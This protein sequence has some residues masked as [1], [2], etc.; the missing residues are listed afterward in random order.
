M[1]FAKPPEYA[2][3]HDLQTMLR[4]LLPEQG[5]GRDGIYGKE[6]HEAVREFQRRQ[7]LPQS[8]VTD[9]KTWDALVRAYEHELVLRSEA[10]ALQI[11]L[12][13]YQLLERGS[14]NLHLYLVQG[15]LKA[16]AQVYYDMPAFAVTGTLDEP[17]AQG[18]IWLQRAAD[19]P[20][21][22]TLDK[23]TW[24]HLAGQYRNMV[25]D[26]TGSFPIRRTHRPAPECP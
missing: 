7:S 10:A 8:G 16:L 17:T 21:T 20:Q 24:R 23:H 26:G 18:L 19:L 1:S 25:G 5:L 9:Q 2:P 3:I 6:T 22:G 4:T 11:V 15:M 13:P 14:K 12:R